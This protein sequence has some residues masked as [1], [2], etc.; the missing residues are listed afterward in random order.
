[1][2]GQTVSLYRILEKLAAGG[3]GGTNDTST[4]RLDVPGNMSSGTIWLTR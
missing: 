4:S 1:M 3:M 2:I